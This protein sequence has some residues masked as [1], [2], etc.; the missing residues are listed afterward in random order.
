[1]KKIILILQLFII[2]GF[3]VQAQ[4]ISG[5]DQLCENS[6]DTYSVIGGTAPYDWTVGN[7]ASIGA[8]ATIVCGNEISRTQRDLMQPLG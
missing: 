6:S 8:N 7:G 1:M 5:P 2:M 3:H 4:N